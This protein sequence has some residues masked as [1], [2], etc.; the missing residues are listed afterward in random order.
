MLRCIDIAKMTR[1]NLIY[2]WTGPL[3]LVVI[4]LLIVSVFVTYIRKDNQETKEYL[5]MKQTQ[6]PARNSSVEKAHHLLP[7]M[8][9]YLNYQYPL[10]IDLTSNKQ[11]EQE[12]DKADSRVWQDLTENNNDFTWTTDPNRSNDGYLTH[13]HTLRGPSAKNLDLD[14]TKE[15]TVI[16]HSA[17]TSVNEQEIQ[18]D[19]TESDVVSNAEIA[20]SGEVDKMTIHIPANV[21]R[22]FDELRASLAKKDQT[23][24]VIHQS[25]GL[26]LEI[27]GQLKSGPSV[28]KHKNHIAIRF[29][30]NNDIA[31]EIGIPSGNE[32]QLQVTVAGVLYHS[33]LPVLATNDYYYSIIYRNGHLLA[34]VNKAKVIDTDVRYKVYFD[35]N[36]VVVNPSGKWNAALKEI[37]L[38]NRALHIVEL[39][40]FRAK[41]I[42]VRALTAAYDKHNLV[43]GIKPPKGCKC[44][45]RCTAPGMKPFNPYEEHPDISDNNLICQA[46]CICNDKKPYD[47][48]NPD[49]T[50]ELQEYQELT[51]L[52]PESGW[53]NPS[54]CPSV[55]KDAD[56]NYIWN[57]VSYGN[58]RRRAREIYRINNPSCRGIPN[59]LDDWYN[60]NEPLDEN[61]PYKIDS[62][63]NPCRYWACENVDWKAHSPKN[64]SRACKRRISAYCEEHPYLDDMCTCWRKEFRD[65]DICRKFRRRIDDP[66]DHGYNAGSFEIYDHPDYDKYI[67]KDKIPCWGC[68][69]EP[70]SGRES[71][72]PGTPPDRC[73]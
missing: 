57:N 37:V 46:A 26:A 33:K 38:L 18:D 15:F 19:V 47:P 71:C 50:P 61:C 1:A 17:A 3:F 30:G 52:G 16:I 58:N 56:G 64:L 68:S 43:P 53:I 7:Y 13:G 72:P 6:A 22:K 39:E 42:I 70:S 14:S 73:L 21:K 31:L 65:K 11:H 29:R 63:F 24:D 41:N 69:L 62:Q 27:A 35:E 45:G 60:K 55:T 40:L 34:Y 2:R 67:R 44:I 28:K 4:A 51:P 36:P 23:Q 25:L 54:V 49:R 10:R 20:N 59:E 9:A 8:K 32:G 48:Y 5:T 12:K 66:R